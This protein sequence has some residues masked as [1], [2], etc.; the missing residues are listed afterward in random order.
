MDTVNRIPLGVKIRGSIEERQRSSPFLARVRWMDP[1]TGKRDSKSQAFQSRV[2]AEVWI[3]GIQDAAAR[4]V[5]PKMAA[6]TLKDYG[7]ANWDIAMR[8]LEPKTIDPYRSG[9]RQ[10]IVPT[11]GHLPITM[12]TAGI[13]DRAVGM[14]IAQGSGK[15]TVKN[16]LAALGRIMDQAVR[17]EVIDRNRVEVPGW[18]KQYQ[19]HED[20]LN[21]PRALAL[22]DWQTLTELA[23][24]LVA[25]SSDQFEVWGE[26]VIYAACTAARIGEVSG[27]RVGD[28]DTEEWIW[29]LRRQTTPGPGGL[30]DKG[31]KGK[32]A[33]AIPIIGELRPIVVNAIARAKARVDEDPAM[34]EVDA[35]AR[36]K[37]C[38][39]ARLFVGPRGG[40][41]QITVL[42]RATR[43]D[44]VVAELGYE[45]LRRHSLRH[46]GL[47]W[48]ADAG[49]SGHLLQKIAGHS[50][51]RVTQLYLH[52]NT[53][54]LQQAGNLLSVHLTAPQRP[55]N[56]H[57]LRL[58]K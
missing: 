41:I 58:I 18:Q 21:N 5:D 46:T 40:R 52:P 47:T 13:A 26:V 43:W 33:R 29:T 49:V 37:A 27:C 35:A 22:P 23:S 10:R 57:Q 45:H 1:V 12:I 51:P 9:W 42:R 48:F 6:A 2:E 20:E 19:R 34:K 8:G 44:E 50:D 15:S 7:D 14:W 25:A 16:T 31:T 3:E 54:A 11:L 56:G 24:A 38:R 36:A 55:P 17:D 4:G 53:A 30:R 28:I 32:R 39:D